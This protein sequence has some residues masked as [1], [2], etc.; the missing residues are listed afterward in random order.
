MIMTVNEKITELQ[1]IIIQLEEK[2]CENCRECDCIKC[3]Y[4]LIIREGRKEE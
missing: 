1:D 4:L 2:Y 3:P